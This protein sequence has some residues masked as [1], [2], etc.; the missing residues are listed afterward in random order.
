M[1]KSRLAH[2][3]RNRRAAPQY[4]KPYYE[5]GAQ[6][7]QPGLAAQL[8]RR[9]ANTMAWVWGCGFAATLVCVGTCLFLLVLAPLAFRALPEGLQAGIARRVPVL[10]AFLPTT[11][12]P[13][14]A[15]AAL[16]LVPTIDP[17][18]ATAAAAIFGGATPGEAALPPTSVLGRVNTPTPRAGPTIMP[19]ATLPPRPTAT[20][21]PLP[22]SFHVGDVKSEKQGWNN[23][24]PANLVQAMRVLGGDLTQQQ[25]AE[26]LKP[27]T[28]DANVSP[29]Q[30]A[31]YA[32]QT[33]GV[34]A[35]VRYNGSIDLLKRLIY[36]GF[37]VIME[38]G[39]YHP[40]DGQWLGHYTTAVGWDDVG[41]GKGGFLYGLDSF[42]YNGAEG[43]GVHEHYADLDERWKHFNR[44]Y[45]VLY[46]EEQEPLLRETLGTAF[47]AR[48]NIEEALL[49][50]IG[51]AR[52]NPDDVFAWFNV[53]TGYTLLGDYASAAAAYD[54]SRSK[55]KGWP[56]RMLWYQFGPYKAYYKVGDYNTVID[57]AS[58]VAKRMP[59]LEETYYYRGLAYAAA[60]Q[61]ERAMTD[62]Q[63]AARFNP[64]F[65][66]AALALADLQAGRQPAPETL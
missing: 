61:P 4:R 60:G 20:R 50:A 14:A 30:M 54:L 25:A 42:E 24:G 53:G 11:A 43:K 35:L 18:R 58:A 10:A 28:N 47:D 12:T 16:E 65:P 49:M 57:L 36:G 33:P 56:W 22:A 15:L 52:R 40:D 27:N 32:N 13:D 37:G 5:V 66:Y 8:R 3:A 46:R 39:L 45:I 48:T 2:T 26:W 9:R 31:A 44:L 41:V 63:Q 17:A 21:Q 64:N 6:Y 55:G 19:T 23:C 38:T 29:W 1:N 7:A 59:H 51:E 34:R 62:L